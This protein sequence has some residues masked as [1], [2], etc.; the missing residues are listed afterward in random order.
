MAL[1]QAGITGFF[2]LTE[3]H[4]L[5]TYEDLLQL[6]AAEQGGHVRYHRFPICKM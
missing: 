3:A 1:L 2:D 6:L 5:A 4:E